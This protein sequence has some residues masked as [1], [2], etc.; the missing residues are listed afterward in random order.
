MNINEAGVNNPSRPVT[1]VE[2]AWFKL[3]VC[4]IRVEKDELNKIS[5]QEVLLAPANAY[6]FH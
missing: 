3:T 5:G 1:C 4:S 6:A 2:P